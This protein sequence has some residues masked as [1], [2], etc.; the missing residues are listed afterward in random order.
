MY[1]IVQ[2]FVCAITHLL[3]VRVPF[4][5]SKVL[6]AEKGSNSFSM[7]IGLVK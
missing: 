3:T 6:L 4:D 1:M 5:N 2:D 7:L